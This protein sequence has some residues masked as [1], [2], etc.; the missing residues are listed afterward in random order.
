M[1]NHKPKGEAFWGTV[2]ILAIV[3]A[4]IAIVVLSMSGCKKKDTT[5]SEGAVVVANKAYIESLKRH[6]A[7]SD[8]II[9]LY[10][11][12]DSLSQS[13]Q[14]EIVTKFKPVYEKINTDT[15]IVNQWNYLHVLLAETKRTAIKR[16]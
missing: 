7:I 16:D 6:I 14:S 5:A 12:K 3:G 4:F 1:M 10:E 9:A 2:L 11:L 13:K 15:G 8:S